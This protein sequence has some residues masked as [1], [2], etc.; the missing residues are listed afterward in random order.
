MAALAPNLSCIVGSHIAAQLMGQAG[1]LVALTKI[2][3]CNLQVMGQQKQTL[4]GFSSQA[5]MK[6]IGLIFQCALVQLT[7]PYLR[8]KAC[9]LVAN[10]S[11]LAIRCDALQRGSKTNDMGIK[12]RQQI[13]AKIEKWQEPK[14]GKQKK[15]LKAPDDRPARKRGGKRH[16]REKERMMM[17]ESRKALNRVG[18]GNQEDEY[19]D[20]AMGRS[21]GML[22]KSGMGATLRISKKEKKK[23]QREEKNKKTAKL[24]T[25]G[26]SGLSSSLAFTPIQGIELVDPSRAEREKRVRQANARYFG[27]ATS[28][29]AVHKAR[30]QALTKRARR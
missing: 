14:K 20:S 2:P 23:K 10:K 4:G 26:T 22:G 3:A 6:H 7:P 21:L 19:G 8:T 16:R 13:E 12:L 25:P 15:A 11:V 28:F 30:A 5:A 17:T 1:G 24:Y 9:R 29:V 18:F 27:T